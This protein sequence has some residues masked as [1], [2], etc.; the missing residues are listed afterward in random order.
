MLILDAYL[1]ENIYS[2][3]YMVKPLH[4]KKS[5]NNKYVYII[6][7][8]TKTVVGKAIKLVTNTEYI[9][10]CISLDKDLN[11]VYGIG[12]RFKDDG[13]YIKILGR[14]DLSKGIYKINNADY[15]QIRFPISNE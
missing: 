14:E 13:S 7:T 4:M 5:K 12:R 2:S 8:N 6:L 9:H 15:V 3:D 1:N 11:H 10:A